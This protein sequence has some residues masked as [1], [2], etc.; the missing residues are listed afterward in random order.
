MRRKNVAFVIF[1]AFFCSVAVAIAYFSYKTDTPLGTVGT[2]YAEINVVASDTQIANLLPGDTTD[3][4]VT[5]SNTGTVPVHIRSILSGS[6]NDASLDSD[7]F[8]ITSLQRDTGAGWEIVQS[9]VDFNT[10]FYFSQ[11]GS[12]TD[13]EIVQ[14]GAQV[15]YLATL[16]LQSSVGNE[17][18][19]NV[20]ES[21]V[22]VEAKQAEAQSSWPTI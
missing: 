6:W 1:L 4:E 8:D 20:F 14:P 12:E 3:I 16:Q 9:S 13:L 11:N 17:Y 2:G 21:Q 10:Y 22:T 19:N 7:V 5:V 18:M 15:K